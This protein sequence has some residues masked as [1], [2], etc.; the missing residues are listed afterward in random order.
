MSATPPQ[1]PTAAAVPAGRHRSGALTALACLPLAAALVLSGCGGSS[2][3]SAGAASVVGG[4]D[5]GATPAQALAPGDAAKSADAAAASGEKAA[6]TAVSYAANQQLARTGS[7]SLQ[8]KDATA[9]AARVRATAIGAGGVV[10]DEKLATSN[11]TGHPVTSGTVTISVPA[12]ALDDTMEKVAAL[13]T[14]LDRTVSTEDV[15]ASMVDTD[16]RIKTMSTS[17][18]RLRA[19]L[20]QATKLDQVVSLEKELTQREA[21]LESLKAQLADLKGR[22]AMSPIAVALTTDTGATPPPPEQDGFLSGLKSGWAA[23]IAST[24]ALLTI[25]G[26][27]LPFAIVLALV[28]IPLTIWLRRRRA[29]TMPPRPAAS[30]AASAAG[31]QP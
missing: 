9:T 7:L 4:A 3:T 8:V 26:A 28:G 5:S 20:S 13:G 18:D 19:F 27:L 30:A 10:T 17:I 14:V 25:L 1:Q 2:S 16:S 24:T 11:D 29:A 31:P 23:L 6:S 21:D 12:S 15:T 22:V